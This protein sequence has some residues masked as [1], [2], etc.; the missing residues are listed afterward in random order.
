[1]TG[2]GAGAGL[3]NFLQVQRQ[4]LVDPAED[5][6]AAGEVGAVHH[7]WGRGGWG[8]EL[9]WGFGLVWI[10]CFGAGFLDSEAVLAVVMVWDGADQ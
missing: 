9:E 3:L 2:D 6:G 8:L 7:S 4:E 5:G 10:V 1:M